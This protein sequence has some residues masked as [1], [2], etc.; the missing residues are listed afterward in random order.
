MT[1]GKSYLLEKKGVI[2]KEIIFKLLRLELLKLCQHKPKKLYLESFPPNNGNKCYKISIVTP[3][4]NQG[5]FIE[6][7]IKSVLDQKYPKTEY[8]IKDGNSTD[9]TK[10]I[11]DKYKDKLAYYESSKDHG[12]YSAVNIGF[13]HSTG[14]IMAYLNSD[15]MLMPG[16]LHFVNHYFKNNPNVDVI[17]GHRVVV[18]ENDMQV[19]RWILAPHNNKVISYVDF[20]PQETLFW[21]RSA[22]IKVGKSIDE[23]FKFA[24]DWDLLMRFMQ[25]G[26]K[27]IRVPY[28]LGIFRF[29][30]AQKSQVFINTI[31]RKEVLKILYKY[32][33]KR[34]TKKMISRNILGYIF[35]SKITSLLFDKGIRV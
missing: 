31:G 28:I 32:H 24:A 35:L 5:G 1:K 2:I 27:I 21:R 10:K 26:A 16:T 6:R 29:H 13:R 8:I 4:Y 34:I 20:V 22:W 15:D 33:Q 23:S 25:S 17:Y 7:T 30:K 12:Q 18:D 19:G 14:E 9:E 3:S 11:I